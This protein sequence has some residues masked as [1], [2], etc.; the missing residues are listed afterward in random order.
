MHALVNQSLAAYVLAM[1]VHNVHMQDLEQAGM[2]VGAH[3]CRLVTRC[4]GTTRHENKRCAC[5]HRRENV[6]EDPAAGLAIRRSRTYKIQ[7]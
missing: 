2:F 6:C 4:A 5:K 1:W 7:A 3:A